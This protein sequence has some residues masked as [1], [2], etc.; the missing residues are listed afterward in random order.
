[1]HLRLG[2][3]LA[4]RQILSGH[5]GVDFGHL[6][7]WQGVVRVK[8]GGLLKVVK[9]FLQTRAREL[10]MKVMTLQIKLV[11]VA[12]GGVAFGQL[13]LLFTAQA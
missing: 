7:I 3:R 4:G 13:P 6:G 5:V 2:H 11:S 12:V 10:I 1:M 9:R 8:V